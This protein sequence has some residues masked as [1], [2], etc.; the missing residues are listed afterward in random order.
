MSPL[1]WELTKWHIEAAFGQSP[2]DSELLEGTGQSLVILGFY[3][4]AL[5]T[6]QE[7]SKYLISE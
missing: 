6:E 4:P 3:H 2:D 5:G 1:L 7:P